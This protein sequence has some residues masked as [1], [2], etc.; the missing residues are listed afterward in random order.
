MVLVAELGCEYLWSDLVVGRKPP[1]D[2]GEG[3]PWRFHR[4]RST[5]KDLDDGNLDRFEVTD[6]PLD[7]P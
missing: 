3:V 4:G 6:A 7:R 2:P 1:E 5:A